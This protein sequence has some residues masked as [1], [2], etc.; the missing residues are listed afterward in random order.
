MKASKEEEE[1]T[2][3]SRYREKEKNTSCEKRHGEA[4]EKYKEGRVMSNNTVRH[5]HVYSEKRSE[6][7]H[8][9]LPIISSRAAMAHGAICAS[10]ASEQ[11]IL[12]MLTSTII[13][14]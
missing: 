13:Y 7:R 2:V 6:K 3:F 12:A 14:Q 8:D 10:S 5:K 11:H 4:E 9:S 1:T